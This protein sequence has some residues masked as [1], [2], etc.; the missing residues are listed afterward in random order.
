LPSEEPSLLHFAIKFQ[1]YANEKYWANQELI[2]T[3]KEPVFKKSKDIDGGKGL[4][5]RGSLSTI[6]SAM[7]N[8]IRPFFSRPAF[9]KK[10]IHT[11]NTRD[12]AEFKSWREGESAKRDEPLRT[13]H[14]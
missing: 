14:D 12:M 11:I 3:D 8:S 4:W 5:N 7:D 1:E 6:N 13:R 10:P 9:I 2:D